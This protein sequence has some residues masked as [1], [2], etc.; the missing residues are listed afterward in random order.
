MGTIDFQ[1]TIAEATSSVEVAE[2]VPVQEWAV[3]QVEHAMDYAVD[4]KFW[5]HVSNGLNLQVMHHLF[6]QVG[7]G[8]YKALVPI[9]AEVCREFGVHYATEP[10]FLSAVQ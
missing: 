7:W 2:A 9:V 6:P 4:S 3:H 1:G 8:H 10:T 5:L